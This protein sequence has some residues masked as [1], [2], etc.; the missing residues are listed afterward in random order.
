MSQQSRFSRPFLMV[1]D[2]AAI[3][4]I[5]PVTSRFYSDRKNWIALFMKKRGRPSVY[6][7][8]TGEI[9]S[10]ANPRRGDQETCV[11]RGWCHLLLVYALASM[12]RVPSNKGGRS[13]S[14]FAGRNNPRKLFGK[15]Y[16]PKTRRSLSPPSTVTTDVLTAI[17]GIR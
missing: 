17:L 6:T 5:S 7:F 10:S 8:E 14:G 3:M 15:G 9:A 13:R 11:H 1:L 4:I 16:S 2:S 12:R